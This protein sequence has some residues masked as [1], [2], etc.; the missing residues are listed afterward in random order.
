L[1]LLSNRED[2]GLITLNGLPDEYNPL[3]TTIRARP[4][5]ITMEEFSSILCSEALHVEA[6]HK[7]SGIDLTVAYSATKV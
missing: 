5:P 4:E 2:F 7:N 1:W 6:E 3:K